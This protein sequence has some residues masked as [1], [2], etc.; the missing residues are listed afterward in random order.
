[1]NIFIIKTD[2]PEKEVRESLIEKERD[3]LN[4]WSDNVEIMKIGETN[5]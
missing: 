4:Q 5:D 2:L 1:M 3:V